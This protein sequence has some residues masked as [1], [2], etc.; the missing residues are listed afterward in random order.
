M[1]NVLLATCVAAAIA[2][3]C[4]GALAQKYNDVEV[5]TTVNVIV[6]Y[7]AG[8]G[9]DILVRTALPHFESAIEELTGQDLNMV[10]KNMPGARGE[11]G[12]HRPLRAPKG[13]RT[14]GG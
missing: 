6:A 13:A 4:A 11:C 10:V 8:G 2:A 1:K 12:W 14:L 5:P 7:N 9:T 3:P